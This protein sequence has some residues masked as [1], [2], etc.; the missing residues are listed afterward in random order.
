MKSFTKFALLSMVIVLSSCFRQ[1]PI[2]EEKLKEEIKAELRQELFDDLL[3]ALLGYI[4]EE[5]DPEIVGKWE[6]TSGEIFDCGEENG[7][8]QLEY[9]LE[10]S[11]DEDGGFTFIQS[12]I[13]GSF[14]DEG[15]YMASDSQLI[16][17]GNETDPDLIPYE[18]VSDVMTLYIQGEE[19]DCGQALSFDRVVS[20]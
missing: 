9:S 5:V 8:L 16:L 1:D 4:P 13:E 6:L 17:F 18:I 3:T 10:I 12:S 11:F 14:E 7:P 19:E 15:L 20:L 2:D